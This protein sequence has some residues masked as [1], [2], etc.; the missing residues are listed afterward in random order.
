MLCPV[1]ELVLMHI[2]MR[3]T[4][5]SGKFCFAP[6]ESNFCATRRRAGMLP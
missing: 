3:Q 6:G 4:S 5:F 2:S 1:S